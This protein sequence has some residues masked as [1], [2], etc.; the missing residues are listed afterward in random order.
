MGKFYLALLFSLY[1]ARNVAVTI[2]EEG[3]ISEQALFF[4]KFI[5]P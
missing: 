3:K 5:A 1:K 4:K 2:F